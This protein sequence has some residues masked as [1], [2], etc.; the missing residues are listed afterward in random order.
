MPE[1]EPTADEPEITT[2]APDHRSGF[3]AIIGRPN[4]G[5]ST[6]L[7]HLVGEKL[8]IRTRR[9]C[10]PRLANTFSMRGS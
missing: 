7:N 9:V 10:S 6:L 3:V 1:H 4:T 2:P 5:K 8:A